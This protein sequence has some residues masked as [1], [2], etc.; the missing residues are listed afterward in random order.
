MKLVKFLPSLAAV[1]VLAACSQTSQTVQQ[2]QLSGVEQANQ[3]ATQQAD[4]VAQVAGGQSAVSV[5]KVT[6]RT[7]SVVYQCLNKTMLTANY[8]F[9]GD[10]VKAVNLALGSGKNV[11]TIPTLI[12]DENNHDF[13]TFVSDKYLWS[14]E[15]GFNFENAT[16]KTGGNL[17]EKG[18]EAD[19]ILAK[20]CNINK[21]ATA[22]LNK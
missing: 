20:L 8:A 22:R 14:V 6:N 5:E 17:T 7:K 16:S 11:K 2:P 19:I 9:E 1:A 15:N 3:T 12:R 21:T 18:S 4:K 10:S 13:V